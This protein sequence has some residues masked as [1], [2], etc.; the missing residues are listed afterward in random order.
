MIGALPESSRVRIAWDA[1]MIVLVLM[2]C[3][4]IPFQFAFGIGPGGPGGV[5]VY[6]IDAIF[7]ADIGL[8][9]RTGYRHAG[10]V[11]IEPRRAA[12]HYLKTIFGL[13]VVASIPFDLVLWAVMGFA[14]E[15][16]GLILALRMLRMLR[17]V[18]LVVILR[19]WEFSG[20]INPGYFRVARLVM[21]FVLLIHWMACAWFLG[22]RL[23]SFPSDSWVTREGLVDATL[24]TQYI[25]S[26]YWTIVTMTTVGYGDIT[27]VRR[28]EYVTSMVVIILGASMYA[29]LIGNIASLLSSVNAAKTHFWNRM[30]IVDQSLRSRHV[31]HQL[32]AR[33]RDYYEY[34]WARYRG[35]HEDEL[36]RDLP[37]P[38]RLEVLR[39]VARDVLDH[40]P[41]YGQC[42]PPLQNELL[43]ALQPQTV[44]PGSL[45]AREGEVGR[46]IY[47]IA[48]GSV[49]IRSSDSAAPAAVLERG[50]CF[51]HLSLVLGERR[52][53]SVRSRDFCDLFVLHHAEFERIRSEYPEFRDALKRVG[54]DRT[55]KVSAML[56]EGIVI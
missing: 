41:L 26:L 5:M 38:M 1:G 35:F 33:V 25:R 9:L 14:P 53:A 54:A 43:L 30:E 19:R 17:I 32:S 37:V 47:F 3:T 46:E 4:I 10:M 55:E 31:P 13:D 27:P 40:V 28:E 36:L 51:G 42:P 49:E 21:I 2:S 22:P 12:R 24:D 23:S 8:N 45:I 16:A 6:A 56:M 20:V 15:G 50:D 7:I 11:I 29:F 18:R 34:L 44:A 48:G 52:T 39:H